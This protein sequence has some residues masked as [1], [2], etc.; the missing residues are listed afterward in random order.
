MQP[1]QDK[2][3]EEPDDVIRCLEDLE[4]ILNVPVFKGDKEGI[5]ELVDALLKLRDKHQE[6]P[7]D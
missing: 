4:K 1:E 2:P 3:K 7:D 6:K 5:E